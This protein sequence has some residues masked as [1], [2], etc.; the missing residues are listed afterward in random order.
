MP[1]IKNGI[2]HGKQEGTE[3]EKR[4]IAIKLLKSGLD[5][6]F[7]EKITELSIKE[8]EKLKQSLK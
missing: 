6:K 3:E 8:I 1:D 4:Q 2:E 5:I 7:V